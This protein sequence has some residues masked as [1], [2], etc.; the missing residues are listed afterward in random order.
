[1]LAFEIRSCPSYLSN[2]VLRRDFWKWHK[3]TMPAHYQLYRVLRALE[4]DMDFWARLLDYRA[5][6]QARSGC[7]AGSEAEVASA[8]VEPA[9]PSKEEPLLEE[10][11]GL[12][13]IDA[14]QY[15][16][17]DVALAILES[18]REAYGRQTTGQRIE[19]SS[20]ETCPAERGRR[21]ANQRPNSWRGRRTRV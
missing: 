11:A 5:E 12:Q 7:C 14:L 2:E 8:A 21:K 6:L 3:T 1:M 10:F 16:T 4:M 19:V 17:L 18:L 9:V 20:P 13:A 15:A